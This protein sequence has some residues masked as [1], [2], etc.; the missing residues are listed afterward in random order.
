MEFLRTLVVF[1]QCRMQIQGTDSLVPN[2]RRYTSPLDCAVQ[3]V[4]NEGVRKKLS[5]AIH[6]TET[7]KV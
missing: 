4:K 7:Y 2:F 5:F 6:R 3:T 1:L